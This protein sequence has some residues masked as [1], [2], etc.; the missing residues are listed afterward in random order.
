MAMWG[1][2][3]FCPVPRASCESWS[4]DQWVEKQGATLSCPV[5]GTVCASGG[6]VPSALHLA[7]L[8]TQCSCWNDRWLC[9]SATAASLGPGEAPRPSSIHPGSYNSQF[10]P[11]QDKSP[12][13]VYNSFILFRDYAHCC[14]GITL[15]GLRGPYGVQGIEPMLDACQKK[16]LPHCTISPA[17][18]LIF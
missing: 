6:C 7:A 9:S 12:I 3:L 2:R 15:G 5:L 4:W 10:K 16:C 8:L 11:L 13:Y 17:Q 14:S 1:F 18:A